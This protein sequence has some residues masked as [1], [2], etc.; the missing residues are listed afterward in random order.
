MTW[1]SSLVGSE[2]IDVELWGY[3]EVSRTVAGS[4]APQAEIRYLYSLGRN[5]PNTGDFSFLPEPREEF[6][7][8]ELG[9]IRITASSKSEGE[10]YNSAA[11]SNFMQKKLKNGL[12][13]ILLGRPVSSCL[14]H[15]WSFQPAVEKQHLHFFSAAKLV[16]NPAL[17][18]L[19][20]FALS[21][22]L[23]YKSIVC[24]LRNVI[25]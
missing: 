9:N 19:Q 1:N 6:S 5:I 23:L 11:I 15:W 21:S 13:C 18:I 10:R 22:V 16:G 4:S 24:P 20:H 25:S 7:L 12:K 3:R 8:W 17:N 2:K 14:L